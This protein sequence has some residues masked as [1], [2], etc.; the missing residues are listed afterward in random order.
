MDLSLIIPA[1]NE[2]PRL[3]PTLS[4]Y[5]DALRARYGDSFEIIVVANSCSDDTAAIARGM[6]P[7]VPQI[8]VL[9]IPEAIGKGG[10]VLAGFRSARGARVLFADA[11][12]A[13]LPQSLLDLADRLETSDI[14]IGS[15]RLSASTITRSQPFTRRL[16][17]NAFALAVRTLFDMPYRDTQC[18]AKAFRW[19]AVQQLLP[20]VQETRWAFDVDILLSAQM[21]GLTVAERPVVWADQQGSSV[22]LRSTSGQVLA[23]FWRMKR[24][25][26]AVAVHPS[27]QHAPQRS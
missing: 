7:A 14:V 18:G 13:T 10:A 8:R 15:R 19:D 12:A 24:R 6:L 2:A 16:L 26:L 9:D 27:R 17:G 11:D 5:S 21:L 23:A 22:R 20:L 25:Q 1:H 3:E 4:V